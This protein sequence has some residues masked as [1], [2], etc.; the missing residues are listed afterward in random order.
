MTYDANST[1]RTGTPQSQAALRLPP[2]AYRY[3]AKCRPRQDDVADRIKQQHQNDRRWEFRSANR[4]A[5]AT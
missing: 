5:S 4:R 3:R 1:R 2:T